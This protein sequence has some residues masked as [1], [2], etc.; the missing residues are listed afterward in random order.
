M[1][2]WCGS[3]EKRK[4]ANAEENLCQCIAERSYCCVNDIEGLLKSFGN[5]NIKSTK[6]RNN[7]LLHL[8]AKNNDQEL[9]KFLLDEG[10]S[11][12]IKNADGQTP[13]DIAKELNYDIVLNLFAEYEINKAILKLN[14]N[15]SIF[16]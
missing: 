14:A 6:F 13:C 11:T 5:L 3:E 15:S 8:A 7:S 4:R 9:V 16:K 1:L 2:R 10:A 12:T